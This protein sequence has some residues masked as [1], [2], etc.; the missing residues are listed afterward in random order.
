MDTLQIPRENWTNYFNDAANR[1]DGWS[2]T[3][4]VIGQDIGDQPEADGLPLTGLS[5]DRAGSEAG[6]IMIGAGSPAAFIEHHVNSPKT[7]QVMEAAPGKETDIQ[8]ESADGTTT[9]VHL[10]PRA[11]LPR[12]A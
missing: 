9:L 1:F 6:D 12:P 11:D 4:E 8:I 5:Y 3:I 10:R 2:T 7:V